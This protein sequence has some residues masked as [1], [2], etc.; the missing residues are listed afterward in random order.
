V[1]K[2]F[3][4]THVAAVVTQALFFDRKAKALPQAH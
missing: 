2:P 1:P 4:E 3:R